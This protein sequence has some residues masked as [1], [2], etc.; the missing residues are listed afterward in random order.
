MQHALSDPSTS[1]LGKSLRHLQ[2][3][4]ASF[5][6]VQQVLPSGRLD[7]LSLMMEPSVTDH[8]WTTEEFLAAA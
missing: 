6:A 5:V 3:A 2:A 1:A 4:I 8:I 7:R